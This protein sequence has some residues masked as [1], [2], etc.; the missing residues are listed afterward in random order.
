M[1]FTCARSC[2]SECPASTYTLELLVSVDCGISTTTV[3]VEAVCDGPVSTVTATVPT[4]TQLGQSPDIAADRYLLD[5][6]AVLAQ[7]NSD[8]RV[9]F[10]WEWQEPDP[11]T[12]S[13]EQFEFQQMVYNNVQIIG[14]DR[15][16]AYFYATGA[17]TYYPVLYVSDG[18]ETRQVQVDPLTIMCAAPTANFTTATYSRGQLE[19]GVAGVSQFVVDLESYVPAND[20]LCDLQ[21][22]WTT[23]AYDPVFDPLNPPDTPLNAAAR[24]YG[25]S[26]LVSLLMATVV[27][28]VLQLALY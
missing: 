20:Q 23:V 25:T 12:L 2:A 8:P 4:P 26:H 5:G 7:V 1:S 15:H 27:V 24:R 3:N 19:S 18:C 16:V 6:S 28:L 13:V 10:W 21:Y 17:G 9:Q 14:V 22:T 11:E